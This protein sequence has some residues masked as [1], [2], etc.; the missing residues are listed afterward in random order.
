[1]RISGN[2]DI[3]NLIETWTELKSWKKIEK[4]L[5]KEFRWEIQGAVKDKKKGRSVG[6][7]LTG[8]K[9]S[10]KVKKVNIDCRDII[11]ID[12]KIKEED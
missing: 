6:G 4:W 2:F 1:M 12:L 5:P 10:L 11:S 7:M 3:V 9:K 8:I